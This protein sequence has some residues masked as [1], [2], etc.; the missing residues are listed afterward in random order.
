MNLR[1]NFLLLLALHDASWQ[2]KPSNTQKPTQKAH[3]QT[4]EAVYRLV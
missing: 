2:N 4:V 1:R 3:P